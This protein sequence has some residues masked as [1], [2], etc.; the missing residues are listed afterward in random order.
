[1]NDGRQGAATGTRRGRLWPDAAIVVVTLAAF[2]QVAGFE[3]VNFDDTQFITENPA[4]RGGL[5]VESLRWAMTAVV[6]GNWIPVTWVSHLLDVQLFGLR[7]GWH[8]LVNLL[9]H[10][11]N[12]ILLRRLLAS[13]TGNRAGSLLAA[14]IFAL[15]PL[16]VEPLAWVAQRRSLLM[17]LFGLLAA[18]TWLRYLRR[19]AAGTYLLALLFFALGLLAKP[20]LATLPLLLLLLDAWP[21]GRLLNTAHLPQEEP[22]HIPVDGRGVRQTGVRRQPVRR[23]P[24]RSNPAPCGSPRPLWSLILE[25][26]PFLALSAAIGTVALRTQ[27]EAMTQLPS[28]G[29]GQRSAHALVSGLWYIGKTVWPS[30][31]AVFYPYPATGDPAPL[32]IGA[33]AIL[34]CATIAAFVL[35]RR[36]PCLA[37]GWAW[38]VVALL[39]VSGLVQVGDQ[40]YADRYAYLPLIGPLVALSGSLPTAALRRSRSGPVVTAVTGGLVLALGAAAFVQARH[41]RDGQTLFTRALDVTAGNYMAHNNLGSLLY[42][43]GDVNGAALHFREAV[44]YSPRTVTAHRNLGLAHLKQGDVAAAAGEFRAAVRENPTAAREHRDLGRTLERLG[45]PREALGVYREALRCNPDDPATR[46]LLERL[47]AAGTR[48][49]IPSPR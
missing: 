29:S 28:I 4:V 7:A 24:S 5:S 45:R 2:G 42:K 39:P 23:R 46:Q 21:F 22:G 37:V 44:R 47:E 11:F 8:H 49:P 20:L 15:H 43:A 17:M 38:F 16:N 48:P 10:L 3:F 6:G 18:Q 35:R 12:A 40:A 27:A 13:V 33:A 14:L 32:V 41:W 34:S 1:M 26:A 9:L 31:L 30:N 25:K 19:P 36:F